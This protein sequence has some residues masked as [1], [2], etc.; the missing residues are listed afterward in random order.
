MKISSAV[1][2][3][4]TLAI[5]GAAGYAGYVVFTR[6]GSGQQLPSPYNPPVGKIGPNAAL[7]SPQ[8]TTQ[9]E[10]KEWVDVARNVVAVGDD[11]ANDIK[12]W[13]N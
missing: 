6:R 11:L 8:K 10:A 3:G 5:I 13:F 2:L 4:L 9:Q 1:G 7:P 12:G